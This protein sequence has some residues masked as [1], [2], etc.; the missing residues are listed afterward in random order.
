M[1]SRPAETT[2]DGDRSRFL[3]IAF[4]G[5]YLV[6]SILWILISDAAMWSMLP[7]TE[8][9]V[10]VGRYKGLVFVVVSS[11][12]MYLILK[13]HEADREA[14]AERLRAESQRFRLMADHAPVLIW[15]AGLDKQ[16]TYFNRQWLQF[17]GRTLEQ[18]LGTGWVQGVH[19][20]DRAHCAEQ[21]SR[22]F[23]ARESF[24]MEYRLRRADGEYRWI[25][26]HGVPLL[27]DAHE[28]SG[29]IG[30]CIDVTEPRLDRERQLLLMRELD[31]R[32]KNSLASVLALADSTF[33]ST[34]DRE[35]FHRAFTGRVHALARS[36]TAL[37]KGRWSGLHI[38][39]LVSTLVEP[40]T[41]QG[42]KLDYSGDPVLLPPQAVPP[43]AMILHELGTNALKHGA[44]R[45]PAGAVT[46]RWT[47]IA[48]GE[49]DRIVEVRW[50]EHG[51]AP[52]TGSFRE[53]LGMKLIRG[54]SELELGGTLDHE[55]TPDGCRCVITF[56]L[57]RWRQPVESAP[58]RYVGSL[59]H[60]P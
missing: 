54:L 40:L 41:E 53:G 51:G 32:V 44:L 59:Q 24:T 3:P 20:D 18:E 26:E 14:A 21:Y 19:P 33:A 56:N 42:Q 23:D 6:A 47:A 11:L 15:I 46:V 60:A 28:F 50:S 10:L 49:G 58:A 22:A 34:T 43:L 4:A 27:T 12:V 16:C 9:V 2:A 13:S 37:A 38:E 7:T 57:D 1:T 30:S 39:E 25:Q 5:A 45:A 36:H 29:Y 55:I 48:A 8:L 52:A 17:T 31:H 35:T